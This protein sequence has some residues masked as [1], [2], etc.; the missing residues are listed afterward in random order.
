MCAGV[1]THDGLTIMEP[2]G[3]SPWSLCIRPWGGIPSEPTAA[4]RGASRGIEGALA[5]HKPLLCQ[6]AEKGACVDQ[7]SPYLFVDSAPRKY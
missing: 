5:L 4:G 7:L 6:L 2:H 1:R 3:Q